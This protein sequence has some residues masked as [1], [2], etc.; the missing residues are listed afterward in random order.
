MNAGFRCHKLLT[1][2][3]TKMKFLKILALNLG[4]LTVSSLYF[5]CTKQ[6]PQ[7]AATETDLSNSTFVQV[8]D[9]TVKSTRNYIYVD[10]VPVS[11]AALAF[12]GVFPGTAFAFKVN[13][14]LRGFLIKDTLSASTQIPLAFA[15]NMQTGR[16]YTI[17]T[18]D[19][20]TS[21]KQAT[22]LNNIVVPKDTTSRLR[23]ANF[24]YNPFAVP[25]VDVYSYRRGTSAPVFSNVPTTQLTDFIPYASGITDTL[26]VYAAG[27]TSPLLVKSQI[28]S[29]TPQR[30]YTAVFNGSYRGTK[31][32]TTFVTY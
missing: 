17:F 9:A 24:I 23:F 10:G 29:L 32:V 2:K 18:Y 21:V 7:V 28:T 3:F 16:S 27:T 30:S 4:T 6:S 13:A 12:G 20:I 15:E 14:G 22:V 26:Y 31:A 11:G 1:R 8:F 5:S 19:T 25:N